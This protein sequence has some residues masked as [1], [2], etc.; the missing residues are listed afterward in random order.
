MVGEAGGLSK[1]IVS[2]S[3]ELAD[4]V[5]RTE[6][7]VGALFDLGFAELVELA[8]PGPWRSGF[9][10]SGF[11][12]EC[13]DFVLWEVENISHKVSA[14]NILRNNRWHELGSTEERNDQLKYAKLMN[15]RKKVTPQTTQ[16]NT[17]INNRPRTLSEANVNR[18]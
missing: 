11:L 6:G 12:I 15:A 8:A 13:T 16:G 3:D 9:R 14:S 7:R 10:V 17:I 4:G 2:A 18:S 5:V 1:D